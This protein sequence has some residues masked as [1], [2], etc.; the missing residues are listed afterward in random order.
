MEKP[1]ASSSRK[2][3]VLLL[4]IQR[5]LTVVVPAAVL[6]LLVLTIILVSRNHSID[7]RVFAAI[8]PYTSP[9]LT[10]LMHFFSFLGNHIFLSPVSLLLVICFLI[11]KRKW[12]AIETATVMISSVLL[13]SLLKRLVQRERPP[14]P[15]VEGITNFSFPSGHSF[16][17]MVFYG[18]MI[19]YAAAYIERKWLRV[20]SILLLSL[21]IAAIG[22]SRIYL[23]VHYASDVVA[24]FCF[25]YIWLLICIWFVD[26]KEAAATLQ[27]DQGL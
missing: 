14:Y 3:P 19:W 10:D 9:G 15:M 18:L 25:A 22:F 16:M 17:S 2:D 23:R 13:M 5:P 20:S 7:N 24:G 11:R 27:K 4:S 6:L 12:M 1:A 26:K 8:A 21:L